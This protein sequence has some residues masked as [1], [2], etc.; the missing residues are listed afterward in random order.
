MAKSSADDEE[1]RR[2]C[3]AAAIKPH[4]SKYEVFKPFF[5]LREGAGSLVLMRELWDLITSEIRT[6]STSVDHAQHYDRNRIFIHRKCLQRDTGSLPKVVGIDVVEWLFGLI[7]R[8]H[9]KVTV[10]KELASQAEEEDMEALLSTYIMGIGEAEEFSDRLK[11]E[12]LALEAANVHAIV[13]SESL[14]EENRRSPLFHAVCSL[15][16]IPYPYALDRNTNKKLQILSVND[17]AL[18]EELD[19]LLERM[20]VPAEYPASGDGLFSVKSCRNALGKEVGNNDLWS[21]GV[22]LG[23]SPPRVEAFFGTRNEIVFEGLSLDRLSLFFIVRFRLSKWF[24]AKYPKI[25]IQEDLLIGD[26]SLADG[27]SVSESKDCS[28]LCWL[29]PPVDFLKMNVDGAVRLSDSIGGIGGILRDWNSC[30]LLTFSEKIGQGSP[31]VAELKAIKR[32]IEIFWHHDG[33]LS[34]G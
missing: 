25:P 19:K 15:S 20:H 2:A 27:I 23:L 21:K 31:P 1:L 22:W 32:G 12:L 33:F 5:S 24:K 10:E 3:E 8:K 34:L 18:I 7:N 4:A 29:H 14:V 6:C 26:P 9:L 11:R 13:E 16:P 30:T 17:K 28:V